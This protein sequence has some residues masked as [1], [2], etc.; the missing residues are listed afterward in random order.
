[1]QSLE[2]MRQ[3]GYTLEKPPKGFTPPVSTRV[4]ASCNILPGIGNFYLARR[5]GGGTQWVLGV[6]NLLLWP[7][8]PIWSIGEGYLD[9]QTVNQRALA[10]YGSSHSSL[11]EN[12]SRASSAQERT[13]TPMPAT[14]N[15]TYDDATK[16]GT[17]QVQVQS[18]M[19]LD[20]ARSRARQIIASIVRDKNVVLSADKNELPDGGTYRSLGETFKDGVLT[21]EF[22][23]VN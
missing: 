5:G 14:D 22:S 3:Q 9:A 10:L 4:A 17:V 12:S 18:G 23:A 8:S 1:M 21:I 20:H 7:I 15:W 2:E 16:H 19:T 6:G 11:A 13:S